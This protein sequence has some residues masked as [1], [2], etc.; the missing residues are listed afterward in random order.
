VLAPSGSTELS[1]PRIA[2][3][4]TT[5]WAGGEIYTHNLV[6]AIDLLPDAEK[7]EMVL[8]DREGSGLGKRLSALTDDT[9]TYRPF[10]ESTPGNRAAA[11]MA[12][13]AR[14]SVEALVGEARPEQARAIRRARA[15]VS[16]PISHARHRLT[17]GPISWIVDLQHRAMPQLFSPREVRWR[18]RNFSSLLSAHGHVVFSSE[19]A[20]QDALL[21]YGTPRARTHVLHFATV[22]D[23]D[24]Q[25]DPLATRETYGLPSEYL[26]V[27]NQFWAHKGHLTLFEALADLVRSGSA[28][29]LVCTGAT[30][31]YRHPHYFPR[32]QERVADLGVKEHT[33]IL[34]KI[35]RFDQV[36]LMKA[37]SVV[38][39]PSLFEGWSTVLEDARVL[40][41]R[42]VASDIS[43]HLEQRLPGA[44][45]FRAGDSRS[46]AESVRQ[47]LGA[48]PV[49]DRDEQDQ[50]SLILD[51]G[52]TFM[53]IAEEAVRG[54]SEKLPPHAPRRDSALLP[55]V[56]VVTPSYNQ[57]EF[58]EL[59][60][61]SVL[62]QDY[63]NLEY[64]I[65][66]GDSTDGSVDII[67]KYEDRLAY[68]VSEPD[69]GQTH[70]INKGW[71]RS[72][73][74]I[75]AY[76]NS[77]DLYLPGAIAA[78]VDLLER[79]ADSDL[80]YG[81]IQT[82][83]ESGAL[84]NRVRP[85]RFSLDRL[86]RS[87]FIPQPT[88]FFR[89][90]LLSEIGFLNESRRFCMDYE[91]WLRASK[92]TSPRWL[93][94]FTAEF[95]Y[96]PASKSSSTLGGFLAEEVQMLN[97]VVDEAFAARFGKGVLRR[98]YLARLLFVAGERS[99]CTSG[100]RSDALLRL[101]SMQPPP[102]VRELTDVIA[103]HDAFLSSDF[104]T[105]G[106]DEAAR[107]AKDGGSDAAG[108]L[109]SL[110]RAGV[111]DAN[112]QRT[113]DERVRASALVAQTV[114]G[115]ARRRW[116]SAA[117]AARLTSLHPDLLTQRGFWLRIGRA[118]PAPRLVQAG[119][120][121]W[122]NLTRSA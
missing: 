119:F 17:P 122:R 1:R 2:I 74:D 15:D 81:S 39:Q 78:S 64:I 115:T 49:S 9:I 107:L 66:D 99:G 14:R 80:V 86:A 61:R 10:I 6:R 79:R 71:E 20:R 11:L 55:R 82:I 85:G 32:L 46:C 63:P 19:A 24:W 87:C 47:A 43:V 90:S 96:H 62:D 121:Y 72:T 100:A 12:R 41:K 120:D 30:E 92:L 3:V 38:I 22:P 40:G 16:Y 94:R 44:I 69:R 98:A 110:V 95:R 118:A 37:A 13:A 26:I 25:E 4:A 18:D 97:E 117:Q 114:A 104:V 75:L 56:T 77:D 93:D 5:G 83:D 73:G 7:P 31:D 52:R 105:A 29:T 48:G 54:R 88:V 58:L 84:L 68:W 65:I 111:A 33:V 21:H 108:I 45:Y 76:L 60:I 50:L 51:F 109:P 34:G 23:P 8:V 36:M 28:V 42:V 116:R 57:A 101:K 27:C 59:T 112:V 70:A 113:V 89:R 67:K 53:R 102:S 106:A 103:G 91:Y 35:P